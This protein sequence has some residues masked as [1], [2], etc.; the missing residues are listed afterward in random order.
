MVA[1]LFFRGPGVVPRGEGVPCAGC[2]CVVAPFAMMIYVDVARCLETGYSLVEGGRRRRSASRREVMLGFGTCR[3]QSGREGVGRAPVGPRKAAYW[4]VR[5][6]SKPVEPLA[7][8][9]SLPRV[10]PGKREREVGPWRQ[11][12]GCALEASADGALSLRISHFPPKVVA[13]GPLLQ[14]AA[15]FP[16]GGLGLHFPSGWS[17]VGTRRKAHPPRAWHSCLHPAKTIL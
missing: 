16:H 8:A 15:R 1:H 6:L 11:Q 5:S 17:L 3:S 7:P 10:I 2:S 9:Q 13:R 14:I 12:V 4:P